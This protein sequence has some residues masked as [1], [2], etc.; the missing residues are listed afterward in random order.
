MTATTEIRS[1][2]ARDGVEIAYSTTGDGDPLVVLVHATG[3][4]KE[5]CDPIISELATRLDTFTA[6]AVDQR[7][8]GD[9]SAPDPPFDWW[10]IGGDV[11]ELVGGAT[12][13][14]GVGHSAGGAA[15]VL[16][17]LIDPGLFDA[18]VLVEPI[19]FP[20]PYGRFPDNPMS[21][22][23]RRR[24]PGFTSRKA[25]YANFVG[26]VAFSGWDDRAMRAYVAGGL[27]DGD[28]GVVLKCTPEAEAEFFM[29]ATEHAAWDRLHEVNTPA[30]LLAGEHS[31]T[32]QEQFLAELTGRF[33]NATY[34]IVPDSS[35]F[36]W[37][38]KPGLIADRIAA[39]VAGL[40]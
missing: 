26:K 9:S 30:L 40:K 35:H 17:D 31:T 32:H 21:V 38:E 12:P 28:D 11:V 33:G 14:I 15:L 19:I 10:D 20:P 5:L 22:G 3:F 25:A 8:H 16:A 4:C 34:E 13:A 39:T 18:L 27:R 7:A 24:K 29:A 1:F 37:M 36:V 23:A 6:V 2:L